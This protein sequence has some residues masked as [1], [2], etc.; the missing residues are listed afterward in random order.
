MDRLLKNS[1]LVREFIWSRQR[2]GKK[3]ANDD[4]SRKWRLLLF[5]GHIS[6]V[7]KA[8]LRRCLD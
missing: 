5:D 7:N 2:F 3:A 4:G 8:F 6:H 1:G